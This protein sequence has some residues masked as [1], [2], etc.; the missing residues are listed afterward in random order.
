M[1]EKLPKKLSKR[2][3]QKHYVEEYGK[4]YKKITFTDM[5]GDEMVMG[6]LLKKSDNLMVRVVGLKG[7][8]MWFA[9]SLKAVIDLDPMY[10]CARKESRSS[11]NRNLPYIQLSAMGCPCRGVCAKHGISILL[12]TGTQIITVAET[13]GR[14]KWLISHEVLEGGSVV[15]DAHCQEGT[16]QTIYGI[17]MPETLMTGAHGDIRDKVNPQYGTREAQALYEWPD[18][19]AA[20]P[21]PAPPRSISPIAAAAAAAPAPPRSISPIL[22]ASAAAPQSRTGSPAPSRSRSDSPVSYLEI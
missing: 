15:S 4:D 22:A 19:A 20:A 6:K 7:E 10:I 12:A 21:A 8:P 13:P 17:F 9:T 2:T 5:F 11:V 3:I 14:T 18:A 1:P 16:Q